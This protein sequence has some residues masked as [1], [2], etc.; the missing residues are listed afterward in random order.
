[1]YVLINIEEFFDAI[2]EGKIMFGEG[3]PTLLNTAYGSIVGGHLNSCEPSEIL[4]CHL[5]Q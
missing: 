4:Q 1:M 3:K 2:R 5:T